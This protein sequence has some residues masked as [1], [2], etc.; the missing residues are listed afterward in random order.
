V[1]AVLAGRAD[2]APDARLP[3]DLRR[4]RPQG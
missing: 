4:Q 3:D 1:A 2:L